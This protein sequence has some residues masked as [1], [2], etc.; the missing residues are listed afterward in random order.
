MTANCGVTSGELHTGLDGLMIVELMFL[1]IM[2]RATHVQ[3]ERER[4]RE[5]ECS[6]LTCVYSQVVD[7]NIH[8]LPKPDVSGLR[9]GNSVDLP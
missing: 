9:H 6:F 8:K 7:C 3:R 5:F 1:P 2:A 4:E